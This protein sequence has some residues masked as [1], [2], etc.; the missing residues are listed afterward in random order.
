MNRMIFA[1]A[2]AA[3]LAAAPGSLA[4]QSGAATGLAIPDVVAQLK[5]EGYTDFHE[6]E[7]ENGRYEVLVSRADGQT[8]EIY[9]D[10][11]T[12]DTLK[13]ERTYLD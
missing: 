10:A 13:V 7:R 12:G 4:Q 1:S 3:W 5:A 9:L 11:R 8:F 2:A 6:I